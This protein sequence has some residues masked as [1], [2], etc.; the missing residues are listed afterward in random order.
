MFAGELKAHV[1]EKGK[2][3]AV[4]VGA[5]EWTTRQVRSRSEVEY[6]AARIRESSVDLSCDR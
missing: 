1:V 3:E 6:E 2:D 4:D 5:S